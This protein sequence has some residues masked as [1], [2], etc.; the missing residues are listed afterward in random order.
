MEEL[1]VDSEEVEVLNNTDDCDRR[2]VWTDGEW[3][4]LGRDVTGDRFIEIRFEDL[5]D[6]YDTLR[7]QSGVDKHTVTDS[8]GSSE[9]YIVDA[10]YSLDIYQEKKHILYYNDHE[11]GVFR[12][13]LKKAQE[14]RKTFDY[15][16]LVESYTESLIQSFWEVLSVNEQGHVEVYAPETRVYLDFVDKLRSNECVK[17]KHSKIGIYI[18]DDGLKYKFRLEV[19]ELPGAPDE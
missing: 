10:G 11:Y 7:S 6:F 4:R 19:E 12:T 17:T 13:A 2:E 1:E 18:H 9:K 15:E 5:R 16:K 3:I 14:K 8:R